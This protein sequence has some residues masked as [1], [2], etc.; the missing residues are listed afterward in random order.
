[1]ITTKGE[2]VLCAN[3]PGTGTYVGPLVNPEQ[4]VENVGSWDPESNHYVTLVDDDGGKSEPVLLDY[5]DLVEKEPPQNG[6]ETENDK[7]I[8]LAFQQ[9][10]YKRV[11]RC[12][13]GTM[14]EP[15]YCPAF[16]QEVVNEILRQEFEKEPATPAEG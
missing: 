13:A 9:R 15:K 6:H 4:G 14:R 8:A 16:N 10:V 1:M 11:G 7:R 3:C 2:V 5:F 12:V